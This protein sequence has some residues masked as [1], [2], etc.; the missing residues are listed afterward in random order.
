VI[1]T[2]IF[3]KSLRLEY[4]TLT[5]FIDSFSIYGREE[6]PRNAFRAQCE[7]Q[8]DE[9][10]ALDQCFVTLKAQR[11]PVEPLRVGELALQLLP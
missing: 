3:G 11:K 4:K 1:S 5:G 6:T 2:K 10:N 7:R 9:Q 8:K